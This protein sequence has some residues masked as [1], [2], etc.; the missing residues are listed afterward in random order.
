MKFEI[1][2]DFRSAVL[3]VIGIGGGGGNAV[4]TMIDSGLTGV[5]FI[6]TNTDRQAL[7]MS[8]APISVQMGQGLGAGSNPELGREAALESQ[9]KLREVLDG[10]DMVFIT[11]GM[12]GGTGTGGAPVIA[13]ISK[14]IGALT[15]AVVTKPFHFEGRRRMTQAEEGIEE[16]RQHVD[17]II[18]IPN[19]KLLAI[20]DKST[21]LLE[22]FK[23]ADEVLLHAVQSISDLITVPGIINLDF[24]DVKAIMAGMGLA[25]MG[26]GFGSGENRA[27]EAAHTAISSPLLE[28][29]AIDGAQGVLINVTGGP[30]LTLAEINEAATL[31]QEAA[32]ENA[33]IIFGSVIDS[34]MDDDVRITVIATGFDR[35]AAQYGRPAQERKV[36]YLSQ[37]YDQ[38]R[39]LPSYMRNGR[40]SQTGAEPETRDRAAESSGDAGWRG[41]RS[42]EDEYDI[43]T[44]LRR[45]AD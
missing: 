32:S 6:S 17:T 7:Q 3:K 44:F 25:L 27:I 24:A 10:S 1:V 23:R 39:E 5:E 19:Q 40:G 15:V 21:T 30:S 13:Q 41:S 12:G 4:N 37:A 43:P 42:E 31:V 11:A 20:A 22:A 33:N 38:N 16:L 35:A 45:R 8:K 26:T 14:E 2:E 9:D 36:T 18:T 29:V 28:N 34:R